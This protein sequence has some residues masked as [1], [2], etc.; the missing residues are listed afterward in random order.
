LKNEFGNQGGPNSFWSQNEFETHF[1]KMSFQT[2]FENSQTHFDKMSF[3]NGFWQNP[4]CQ[5]N[6]FWNSSAKL[7]LM[8]SKTYFAKPIFRT[9]ND[10]M[11][12][13]LK[14]KAK[15]KI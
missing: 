14:F 15:L 5:Q 7:I 4:F 13:D 8:A 2:H 12:R 9:Q 10:K 11:R 6:G 1:D 3:Q